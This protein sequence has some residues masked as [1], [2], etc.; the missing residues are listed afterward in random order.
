[1]IN[2]NLSSLNQ[3]TNKG[4]AHGAAIGSSDL[5]AEVCLYVVLDLSS[6]SDHVRKNGILRFIKAVVGCT[7]HMKIRLQQQY[8]RPKVA[9]PVAPE[10]QNCSDFQ[11][12]NLISISSLLR[13]LASPNHLFKRKPLSKV[14]HHILTY[15]IISYSQKISNS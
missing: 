6:L 11:K 15:D 14:A 10:A 3:Q 5:T 8:Y 13:K 1:M 2:L 7:D 9:L 4:T 12:T